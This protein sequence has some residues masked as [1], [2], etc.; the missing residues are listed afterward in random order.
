VPTTLDK[1]II[2]RKQLSNTWMHKARHLAAAYIGGGIRD[3]LTNS[4]SNVATGDVTKRL[5]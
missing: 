1:N 5:R 2:N 4:F 3:S